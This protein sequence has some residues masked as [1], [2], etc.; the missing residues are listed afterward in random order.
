MY[1]LNW[2]MLIT[3]VDS[4]IPILQIG[5]LRH[6]YVMS[7]AQSQNPRKWI[8]TQRKREIQTNEILSVLNKD[9]QNIYGMKLVRQDWS[10][11]S[12]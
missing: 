5:K 4:V 11:P 3:Q 6:K 12:F 10:V 9:S 1:L 8:A 2:W 7:F